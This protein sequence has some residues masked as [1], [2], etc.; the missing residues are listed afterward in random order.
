MLREL[1]SRPMLWVAVAFMAGLASGFY[2]WVAVFG[3]GA[4]LL[5]L[6]WRVWVVGIGFLLSGFYLGP[7][8]PS[9]IT[10]SLPYSGEVY[11]VQAPRPNRTGEQAIVLASGK[12]LV[13]YFSADQPVALGDILVLKGRVRPLSDVS[14]EYW[15]HQGVSGQMSVSGA[16]T[17]L[18]AGPAFGRIGQDA[19]RDFVRFSSDTLEPV[20][21]A[22]VQ[23]LCFNHDV[24]LTRE[25]RDEFARSGI[26]HIIST[27]GLHV[28][29]VA[30]FLGWIL[31]FLPLPRALQVGI[32]ISI[33]ILFGAA[34]GFRPPMV[35]S[36][37]MAS[38]WYT[39]Y[40]FK[41]EAD[42][43]SVT[44]VSAI[45]T[46]LVMP[47]SIFDLGF[48][49]SFTTITALVMFS[50]LPKR[51][52]SSVGAVVFE[53]SKQIVL[54]S[55]IATIAAAP[56]LIQFFGQ[57]S[58]AGVF[59]NLL[60]VPVVPFIVGGSLIA[61]LLPPFAS[62]IADAIMSYGVAP[63]ALF[64]EGV[65]SSVGQQPWSA[66]Q[67]PASHPAFAVFFYAFAVMLWRPKVRPASD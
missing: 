62:G 30:G 12:R 9:L 38:L 40:L 49:L 2:P 27:S 32:L 56:I 65:G 55:V 59:T 64:V 18:R 17:R 6:R 61:W 44:A 24:N 46:L 52:F 35:R 54:S 14:R 63:L 47:W 50:P 8:P 42:G 19:R 16:I 1:Q 29:L 20:P 34:A 57:V 53:R 28:V 66:V 33:L 3:I 37:L 31:A 51:D 15:R 7:K 67:F 23:A 21:A 36:I 26:V 11:V 45:V 43:L 39:A 41:R 60:V 58:V 25:Q 4:L 22:V 10:E 5:E 13:M 48:L